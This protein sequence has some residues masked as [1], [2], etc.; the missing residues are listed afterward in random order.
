MPVPVIWRE[1]RAGEREPD[2]PG[3][4]G[5]RLCAAALERGT[6]SALVVRFCNT[7]PEK[8]QRR[9]ALGYD[10]LVVRAALP[11]GLNMAYD[12]L[13]YTPTDYGATGF[14]QRPL[15]DNRVTIAQVRLADPTD[16][17]FVLAQEFPVGLPTI[18]VTGLYLGNEFSDT[19][20]F[21]PLGGDLE[22]TEAQRALFAPDWARAPYRSPANTRASPPPRVRYRGRSARPSETAA[23]SAAA[24]NV[25]SADGASASAGTLTATKA[26]RAIASA[27]VMSRR[28]DAESVAPRDDTR[29]TD[30]IATDQ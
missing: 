19:Q 7:L 2:P 21:A 25:P 26:M 16:L 17:I 13:D 9:F 24:T 30:A 28:S 29:T 20:T 4:S 14:G 27:S 1:F 6:R 5:L 8:P 15:P 23:A 12:L 22:R 3:P 11:G 10:D 18:T